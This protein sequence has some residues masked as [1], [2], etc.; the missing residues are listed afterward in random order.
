MLT[1]VVILR[2]SWKF[3]KINKRQ[4]HASSTLQTHLWVRDEFKSDE[5]RCI[6]VPNDAKQL[7]SSG[8]K[9]TVE[10]SQLRIF[11][12]SEYESVGCEMVPS[13][14]WIEAPADAI[15]CGLKELP[16][17]SQVPSIPFELRHKHIMFGHSYKFQENWKTNLSRFTM[18]GGELYDLEYLTYDNG[19]RVAAFGHQAGFAGMSLGLLLWAHNTFFGRLKPFPSIKP[20]EAKSELVADIQESFQKITVRPEVIIVGRGHCGSGAAECLE[21]LGLKKTVCSSQDTKSGGPFI[22]MTKYDILVNSIFLS[23]KKFPS[24]FRG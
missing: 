12:D 2:K 13:S 8:V 10:S 11:K 21:A 16:L 5:R 23:E 20:Y 15:I 19:K 7:L 4:F 1:K 18:G 24:A 22:E 3:A 14:S 6:L 17:P 9:V